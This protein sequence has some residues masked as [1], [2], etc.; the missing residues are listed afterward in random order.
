MQIY[1]HADMGMGIGIGLHMKEKPCALFT[2]SSLRVDYIDVR[3]QQ[4]E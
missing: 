4:A 1:A 3:S 2:P